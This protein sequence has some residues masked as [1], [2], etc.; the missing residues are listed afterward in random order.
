[1]VLASELDLDSLLQRIADLSRE[2]VGAKYGAV[3]VLGN[4][5]ELA[6]FVYSGLDE[7]TVAK[8]G[9][10]PTGRGVLGVLIREG[11]PLRMREISAHPSSY[12]FPD[13]HPPM[14]SFLGVPI[15]VRGH[16][17]GRL[18][19][20]EKQGATEFSKDDE[21]IALTLASQAAIAIENARLYD[22]IRL[23]SE[24]LARRVAELA[25]VEHVAELLI[26]DASLDEMLTSAGREAIKLTGARRSTMLLLDR[27]SGDLVI[28]AAVG[29]GA[30]DLIG[31][32]FKQ[33]S[34]KAYAVMLRGQGEVVADLEA[35]TE[36][37]RD[38]LERLGRPRRGAFVP[39][40]VRDRGIGALS[41]YDREDDEPF[42]PDDLFVLQLLANQI[43][44]AVEN[45]RLTDSLQILA[46]LEERDRISKELHDGVIQS[47]YS[48]GLSLQG[49]ISLLDRDPDLAR[50]RID[51]VI[52]QLDNVVRDVRSYIFELQPKVVEGREF[53]D[54]IV[55][56]AKDFEVNTLASVAIDVS[57]DNCADLDERQRSNVIQIMREVLSNIA[58]HSQASEVSIGC[59]F[60]DG[61]LIFEVSDNGIGFDP[62]SVKRGQ[63]L[64]NMHDRALRLG[65]GL[66]I[67]GRTPH[68]TRHRLRVPITKR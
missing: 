59:S 8:I 21:R 10:L 33:G 26:G 63:G 56:L 13:A 47:I 27:A 50:Q 46:V 34:A 2:V 15:M 6:K 36:V 41:V 52:A 44:I 9:E 14:H 31:A 16:I 60:E 24:E 64:R 35:D 37:D 7:E 1:M 12:G 29:E 67:E 66:E 43:A 11:K 20:T 32:R 38:T 25:S 30:E 65:G 19:V 51:G 58:R 61:V 22:E 49:S 45:D 55:E 48:V 28:R 53:G 54:A 57:D 17:F 4:D 3:G 62:D 42:T 23:R 5:G 39:L 68:G 40:V 18:Y